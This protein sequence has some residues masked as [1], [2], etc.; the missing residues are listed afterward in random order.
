M[1]PNRGPDGRPIE[2]VFE[3]R[4]RN[5]MVSFCDY[6]RPVIDVHNKIIE[7]DSSQA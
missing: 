3:V 1:K 2:V 5:R 4:E 6:R 7:F